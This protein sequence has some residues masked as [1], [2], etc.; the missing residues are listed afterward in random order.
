MRQMKS[1]AVINNKQISKFYIY[2]PNLALD[3]KKFKIITN[4]QYEYFCTFTDFSLL[5]VQ[6]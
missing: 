4:V 6:T 5:R 2:M 3:I 1:R